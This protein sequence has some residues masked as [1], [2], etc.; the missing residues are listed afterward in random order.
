MNAILKGTILET[1]VNH[2]IVKLQNGKRLKVGNKYLKFY[3]CVKDKVVI[4]YI[5]NTY[6]VFKETIAKFNLR[7]VVSIFIVG[8]SIFYGF[9]FIANKMDIEYLSSLAK[10]SPTV[11]KKDL[12]GDTE[13]A[14]DKLN[15]DSIFEKLSFKKK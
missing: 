5:N 2:I 8:T 4:Y 1:Y 11:N 3:P 6:K 13:K 15:V 9:S 10:D 7:R 14:L 12:M